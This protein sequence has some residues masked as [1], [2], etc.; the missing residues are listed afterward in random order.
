[1]TKLWA[2]VADFAV[3]YI[4]EAHPTDGWNIRGNR[5][6]I[7]QP[8]TVQE[9]LAAARQL[10]DFGIPCPLLVDSCSNIACGIFQAHPERFY[11]VLDGIVRYRGGPGPRH[12]RVD[13]V[14]DWL[15]SYEKMN[16]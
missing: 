10:Y 4:R 9:R 12:Y 15:R 5:Y 14:D 7:R 16:K 11:I 8:K 13:E 6:S 2:D 3:I 1:M